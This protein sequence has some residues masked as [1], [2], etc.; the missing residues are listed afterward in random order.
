MKKTFGS[1]TILIIFTLFCCFGWAYGQTFSDKPI[2][3]LEGHSDRIASIAFSP[4][5][6]MLASVGGDDIVRLWDVAGEREIGAFK[7]ET[8]HGVISVAFT[9]D[10]KTLVVSEGTDYGTGVVFSL[11]EVAGQRRL[12]GGDIEAEYIVLSVAFSPD[13]QTLALGR[14]QEGVRLWDV[15]GQAEIEVVGPVGLLEEVTAIAFSPDMKILA[16][17]QGGWM[18]EGDYTVRL[19]E[20]PEDL[21]AIGEEGEIAI[22]E[23]HTSWVDS[24]AFSPDGRTL[25][26]AGGG[27]DSTVRLWDVAGAT[28]IAVLEWETGGGSSVAFSPDGR[29]L[30]LISGF[31]VR[32]WDVAEQK[33]IDIPEEQAGSVNAFSPDWQILASSGWREV[34][35]QYDKTVRLWDVTSGNEIAVLEGHTSYAASLA[36]SPDGRMLASGGGMWDSSILLW[37]EAPSTRVEPKGKKILKWGEVK[38]TV[39]RQN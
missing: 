22:L 25:V 26:S 34:L 39:L 20:V 23:G 8:S 17:G 32:L 29:L 12:A 14:E 19:W 6:N 31:G 38:R 21:L 7:V 10:G 35:G 5:G 36:F 3:V 9:S 18:N 11:W 30:T 33:E 37:G 24:L 4:D 2:A 15:A 28:E 1:R 27:E 16:T 13:G